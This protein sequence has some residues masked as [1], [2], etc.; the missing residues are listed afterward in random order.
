M[1]GAHPPAKRRRRLFLV[2]GVVLALCVLLVAAGVGYLLFLR[3]TAAPRPVVTIRWSGRGEKV[4]VGEPVAL[5]SV[6]EGQ[7]P[8]VRVELW[9]DGKLQDARSTDPAGG[10]TPFVLQSTWRP[11]TPGPHTLMARAFDAK[12][13]RAHA[14]VMVEAVA[15]PDADGDGAPDARDACPDQPGR[16]TA[17]GC[18][19]GDGDGVADA[20]DRCPGEAGLAD[21]GGC[22]APMAGDRDGDGV[23][24]EADLA[25]DEPGPAS[26]SG[27]PDADGD[28]V[29]DA[30][31]ACPGEPGE[32]A[33][34]CAASA[35]SDEDTVPDAEDRC[36]E[37]WGL[38][39]SEGCPDADGDG[40]ADRRDLCPTEPG[41][42]ERAGCPESDAGD[43]D[44]DGVS[45][46]HDLAP[47]EPGRPEDG[48]APPPGRGSDEDHDGIP[49][50][51]EPPTV[52]LGPGRFLLPGPELP[53][54]AVELDALT[55]SVSHD[56]DSVR[57]YACLARGEP[58]RVEFEPLGERRWDIA[59]ELGGENARRVSVPADEP[60]EVQVRCG[61]EVVDMGPEGGW[62]T[63]YDLGGFTALHPAEDWD[64][65]VITA[66][67]TP[68]PDGHSFQAQYRLCSG[69][70]E[71]AALPPPTL[72]LFSV[73]GEMQLIWY[74]PGD[75]DLLQGYKV[76]MDGGQ[77]LATNAH[78]TYLSIDRYRP[79]CGSQGHEFYVTASAGPGRESPPSNTRTLAGQPCP[80]VVRV[81]FESIDTGQMGDDEWWADGE[82]VGPT[83]GSFWAQGAST[84]RLEFWAV[85]YGEWWGQRDDGYRLEHNTHYAIQDIFDR[86]WTWI[87]G[88][89]SSPYRVPDHNYVDVELDAYQALVVGGTISDSDSGN[90]DDTLFDGELRIRPADLAPGR[91]T[92]S[93]RNI[94]LTVLVDIIVG[95]EAGG[96][97]DLTVTGV[98]REPASGQLQIHVFNSAADLSSQDIDVNVVQVSTNEQILFETWQ[99]VSIPSGSSRIMQSLQTIEPYDLRVIV[100]PD[101]HIDEM[102]ERNNIYETTVVMRVE[103]M[104]VSNIPCEYTWDRPACWPYF[105]GDPDC[106]ACARSE[107]VFW[108]WAG[109][110]Q[111]RDELTWVASK[112]RFPADGS[113]N[114]CRLGTCV[115]ESPPEDWR[116]E[117]NPSYTFEFEMPAGENLY[118][119]AS[120]AE[121]DVVTDDDWMGEVFYELAPRTNW[122]ARTESYSDTYGRPAPCD[123]PDCHACREGL[124]A[125]WRITRVH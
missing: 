11:P 121:Q 7:L 115:G 30:D 23:S 87:L 104:G 65:H 56:Y 83:Y 86:I 82:S 68:G 42:P 100:D 78:T 124:W 103:F 106:L 44:G 99:D 35:D 75:R 26:A 116:M 101:N 92:V 14:S 6:A 8:I 93:D 22:P 57:C 10:M 90:P 113:L 66:S 17:R 15:E 79:P 36:P 1:A 48:G 55:F 112:V 19:D 34:G 119:R 43:R 88:S 49:D 21:A 74:W 38:P 51:E 110:G 80:R 41:T 96:R 4:R 108:V 3:P 77:I 118:V 76:Y 33:D 114:A 59:A 98:T 52:P 120:G 105:C 32:G 28:G 67:S 125:E 18:P 70:C 60:L 71:D 85:D 40:V 89:M 46:D 24:D 69:S 94:T 97:P 5:H 25:P 117:G 54:V 45:D 58:E 95:P 72:S 47:E 84:E 50:D 12:G 61:A 91:Y 37:E 81:T 102:D 16:Y 122:G 20:E 63:Y 111:S 109:H 29:P 107:H 73:S 9:A 13:G 27:R 53:P 64:G 39:G 123:D 62:G 2:L 31:D